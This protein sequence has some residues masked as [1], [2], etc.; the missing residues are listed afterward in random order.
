[1][2]E[3]LLEKVLLNVLGPYIEGIDRN[4]FKLGLWK[5]KVSISQ[6]ALKP[7]ILEMFDLP[8]KMNYSSIGNLSISIPWKNLGSKPIELLI[9][10]IH[11]ILQPIDKESWKSIDFRTLNQKLKMMNTFIQNYTAKMAQKEKEKNKTGDNLPEDQS[12]IARLTEKAIDNIQITIRNIHLRFED[13]LPKRQFAWGITLDEIL[14]HT[15]NDN[16]EFEFIDRTLPENKL[17]PMKKKLLLKN[18]GI[19]WDSHVEVLYGSLLPAMAKQRMKDHI[20]RDSK[21]PNKAAYIINISAEC[22][23]IQKNKRDPETKDNPEFDLSLQIIPIDVIV[24]KTQVEDLLQLVEYVNDYQKFKFKAMRKRQQQVEELMTAT[25]A[26]SQRQLQLD[27]FGMLFEKIRL[28]DPEEGFKNLKTVEA[29]LD[30]PEQSE[31]FEELLMTLPDQD[32]GLVMKQ[33]L[34]EIEK[35]KKMRELSQKKEKGCQKGK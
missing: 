10:D 26:E 18:L 12:L 31:L 23:L 9:E 34:K 7:D 27:E 4:N 19:Y 33:K 8:L 35:N 16:W 21:D 1:M 30:G 32:I 2:F 13:P 25:E 15:T 5:G 20:L 17:L 28:K 14:L 29:A 3:R 6:V 24:K 22:R 11:L